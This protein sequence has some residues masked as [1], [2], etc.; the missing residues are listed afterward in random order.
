MHAVVVLVSCEKRFN[1]GN[2]ANSELVAI[3]DN[4]FLNPGFG[5]RS[6]FRLAS[7]MFVAPSVA[8]LNTDVE[9]LR[10]A[11]L[12][13]SLKSGLGNPSAFRAFLLL[14]AFVHPLNERNCLPAAI[15]FHSSSTAKSD[16][17]SVLGF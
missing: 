2:S 12:S 3:A 13:F 16:H 7:V 11:G 1:S 15:N 6:F 8:A 17:S 10:F 9:Y 5:L 14:I 4:G